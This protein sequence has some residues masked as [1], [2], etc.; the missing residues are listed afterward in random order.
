MLINV[1]KKFKLLVMQTVNM[2]QQ[3][4]QQKYLNGKKKSRK[5]IKN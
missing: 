5:C 4:T 3:K 1:W 2:L